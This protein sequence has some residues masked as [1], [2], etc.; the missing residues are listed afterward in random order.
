VLLCNKKRGIITQ[1]KKAT[2]FLYPFSQKGIMVRCYSC[3]YKEKIMTDD[4]TAVSPQ[5]QMPSPTPQPPAP[6][7]KDRTPFWVLIAVIVGFMLPVCSCGVLMTTGLISAGVMGMGAATTGPTFT[8]SG[9]GDSVAVVRIEGTILSGDRAANSTESFSGVVISEL[10]DAAANP[11][12]KAIV[13]RVDSPGG[14]VTGSSQI[15]EVID[16]IEKP[17]VASMASIAASG[18]Y[19]VSAPADYIIARPDTLTGSLGVIMTL[20]D[21]TEL[22][23]KVG[24]QVIDITSGENKAIGSMF[25]QMTPEQQDIL[26]TLTDES[27]AEFVRVISE[28]R[29]MSEADVL[30]L[31]DGRIYSGRQALEN[32]LVDELG[33]FDDAIAKAAELGGIQGDPNIM[34]YERIPTFREMLTG[35]STQIGKT[36]AERAMELFTEFTAPTLEYRYVGPGGE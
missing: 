10:E 20:Y 26:Q 6:E 25:T 27:Y 15:W 2:N 8:S 1:I 32:G 23:D 7:K 3:I 35:F 34:E 36:D 13:L 24:L 30:D 19:Y 5:S 18:G 11:S 22:I 17:V 14:S 28:G 12:V 31:A 4:T 21:A 33:N 9:F 16:A 29:G